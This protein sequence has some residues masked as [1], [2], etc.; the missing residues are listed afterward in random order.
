M[1][2]RAHAALAGVG[3]LVLLADSALIGARTGTTEAGTAGARAKTVVACSLGLQAI[4]SFRAGAT[5]PV[6]FSSSMRAAADLAT[7][8]ALEDR[9][10]S[11]ASSEISFGM[12]QIEQAT[13]EAEAGGKPYS[14]V[15]QAYVD[16]L[17]RL[18][19]AV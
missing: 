18:C 4:N 11:R 15:A 12:E 9:A 16:E 6:A 3:L 5:T 14:G 2:D 1:V 10:S 19:R 13:L 7:K 8:A 17:I